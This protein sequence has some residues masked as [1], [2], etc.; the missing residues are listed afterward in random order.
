MNYLLL[1][2]KDLDTGME[3]QLPIKAQLR[4]FSFPVPPCLPPGSPWMST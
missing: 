1:N 3:H 2:N 4:A